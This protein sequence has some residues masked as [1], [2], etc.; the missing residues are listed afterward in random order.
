MF[1]ALQQQLLAEAMFDGAPEFPEHFVPRPWAFTLSAFAGSIYSIN[2]SSLACYAAWQGR[3]KGQPYLV[4][5]SRRLYVQALSE[6]QRA[7]RDGGI[8]LKDETFGACT[9]LMAYEALEC[10]DESKMAFNKHVEGCS[11]LVQLRGAK[12][13]QDGAAHELFRAFRYIEVCDRV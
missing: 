13:H 9:A 8:A 2:S 7:V 5:V 6:L 4:E 12:V 10:P 11:R 1:T 3:S